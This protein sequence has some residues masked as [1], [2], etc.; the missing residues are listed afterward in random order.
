MQRGLAL[1]QHDAF[2]AALADSN[3]INGLV[4]LA[5]GGTDA[6]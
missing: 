4:C 2:L 5:D 3:Q 1:M 6:A